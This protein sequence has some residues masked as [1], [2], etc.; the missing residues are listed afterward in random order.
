MKRILICALAAFV[1]SGC[2]ATNPNKEANDRYD[3]MMDSLLG[4]TESTL[5]RAWGPPDRAYEID[6]MKYLKYSSA[7]TIPVPT[8]LQIGG[9]TPNRFMMYGGGAASIH[10]DTVFRIKSGIVAGYRFNGNGCR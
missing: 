5:V 9:P 4:E 8:P 1:I 2:A 3:Q 7:R 10:C 6:D